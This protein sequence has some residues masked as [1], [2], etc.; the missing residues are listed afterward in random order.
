MGTHYVCTGGC[1][2]VSGTPGVCQAS[3]CAD[4][5]KSLKE[6]NCMDD[7]HGQAQ[8]QESN[9]GDDQTVGI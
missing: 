7:L 4:H 5:G 1:K 6:C 8:K 9:E 3:D 2:G